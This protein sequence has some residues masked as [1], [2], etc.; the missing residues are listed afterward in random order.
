MFVQFFEK[1]SRTQEL[2]F[3]VAA[4]VIGCGLISKEASAQQATLAKVPAAKVE[5]ERASVDWGGLGWGLGIATNFD[6]GG[7]R[8]NS[9]SV[10]NNVVRVD[11]TSSNVSISFVLEAHYFL[12]DYLFNW[13]VQGHAP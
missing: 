9:A 4:L 7:K 8:V 1:R 6:V 5:Q 11:D 12:R 3:G 2:A 10:V 13:M